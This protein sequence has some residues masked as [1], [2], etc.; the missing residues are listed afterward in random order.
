MNTTVTWIN[1]RRHHPRD[2]DLVVAAITG[3]YPGEIGE[4]P[5]SD[6]DFWLVLP[7]H[8]RH[9]HRVE[10]TG[11]IIWDCYRDADGVIRKAY[12]SGTAEEVTHWAAL[13]PLP[14]LRESE[15]LGAAVAELVATALR[16]EGTE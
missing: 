7:G 9:M 14:G 4:V 6:N 12:G 5:S 2:G 15:V 13:P 3:R 1:A 10:E 11:D 8:F 16:E